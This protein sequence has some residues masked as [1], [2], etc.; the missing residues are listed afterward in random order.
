MIH[1][2]DYEPHPA[3]VPVG[4]SPSP[5]GSGTV[6]LGARTYCPRTRIERRVTGV[7]TN[8]WV[9]VVTSKNGEDLAEGWWEPDL[10]A[11]V[12]LRWP[13]RLRLLGA[14]REQGVPHGTR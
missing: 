11:F 10:A 9:Y 12:G 5:E 7:A 14:G 1:L 4:A 6:A 3:A 13:H 8:G 2:V